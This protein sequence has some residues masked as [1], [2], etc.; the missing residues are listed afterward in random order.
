[1]HLQKTVLTILCVCVGCDGVRRRVIEGARQGVKRWGSSFIAMYSPL[2]H[3][4]PQGLPTPH[5]S[6]RLNLANVTNVT[7]VVNF[8]NLTCYT[9]FLHPSRL[10]QLSDNYDS[11]RSLVRHATR[12]MQGNGQ[13]KQ[14]NSGKMRRI[15]PTI[16][17]GQ[18]TSEPQHVGVVAETSRIV[19]E[20]LGARLM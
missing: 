9:P 4:P 6:L 10:L 2:F 15:R 7:N 11:R 13:H 8:A 1:M 3:D 20:H 18:A 16:S 19:A 14:I 17:S 5:A 12:V